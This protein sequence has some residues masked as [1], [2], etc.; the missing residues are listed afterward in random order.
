MK[1]AFLVIFACIPFYFL[2]AQIVIN[3]GSNKNYSTL[4]DEDGEYPDWI[5]LHN[6]GA[7]PVDVYNYSLTDDPLI[8][9][10]WILPHLIIPAGGYTVIF[11]SEKDRYA[12]TAF[13]TVLNTGSFI[14]TTGWNLHNFTTPFNW[15][16]ISNIVINV[17]SYSNTGYITNSVHNQSY[18]NYHSTLFSYEDGSNNA[19][20][21]QIG[22]VLAQRPN[23][24]LNGLTIGT[25]SVMN[26][27]YSYPAPYGNWYWGARHQMMIKQPELTAAGLSAGNIN[28]LSFDIVSTDSVNYTY[29]EYSILA[30]NDYQMPSTYYPLQ[31]YLNH[32]N[33]KLSSNGEQVY[34]FSPSQVL[35]SSLQVDCGSTYD[36]SI[37]SFPDG[38]AL[39]KK[40]QPPTPNATNNG[41]IPYDD[42]S[43]APIFSVNS[44]FHSVPFSVNIIDPNVPL[45]QIYYTTDGS[46]P[47]NSD[48]LFNGTP[49]PIYQTTV[50]RAKAYAPGFLPSTCTSVSYFFNVD[51]ITP[52]ISLVTDDNNLYGPN[53]M[54]DNYNEDWLKAAHVDYF[55]S[56]DAHNLLFKRRVGIIMDGGWGGSRSQPQHS[57]RIKFAD[58]VLG[59][60]LVNYQVIPDRPDRTIFSD[61][62][63][64]N[65]SNQYLQFPYKDACQVK[66]LAKGSNN[67][68]SAWRPVSVYI[69]GAYFGL[70]ELREKWNMEMFNTLENADPDSTEIL[71]L[72][73]F[74]NSTLRALVG[75]VQNFYDDYNSFLL[76]NPA[77]T[78][79]WT[80][81]DQYFDMQYYND[82]IIAESWM[83]NT[84]WPH[85]NVKI[86]RSN[87][88][89]HRWRFCLI[90]QE[91]ALE[92]NGWT[93]CYFDHINYIINQNPGHPYINIWMVG[94][95][96][97][98]FKNYFINR[99]ADLMN[100]L[101]QPNRMLMIEQEMFDQ[102]ASEMANEFQ[103]WGDPWNVPAQM[104]DFYDN[105][106]EFRDELVCRTPQVRNHI[107]NNYG[108]PQQVDVTLDVYPA[109]AGKIHISTITPEPYPWNG[110][111]FD[112]LPVK[113]EAIADSGYQFSHWEPNGLIADT[114]NSVYNDT[115]TTSTILFKAYFELI[116]G[117]GIENEL[118][119]DFQLYPS[120]TNNILHV[121]NTHFST[122]KPYSFEIVDIQGRIT[123]NGILSNHSAQTILQ[124][125][126]LEAGIYF[127]RL[128]TSS[129]QM[130][131]LKFVKF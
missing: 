97:G 28:S 2:Q 122:E 39:I 33:F 67:Y 25:D 112:G 26:S 49:I 46:E 92:P 10:K 24:R 116:P 32:T 41:S 34:L 94:M 38:S 127:I 55:D 85:N 82:Y 42:F 101:Y 73:A 95:Q 103:R 114:L 77:D 30:V 22:T 61:F 76:I 86:Y 1:K 75:D 104:M 126:R 9:G 111:Y 48:I 79:F 96:N 106:L 6:A 47:D 84:D 20:Y 128:K 115:L 18:T 16:G 23:I 45:A 119:L 63:L 43:L 113:I 27:P 130:V 110:I 13:T 65:G 60:G 99:F 37:G 72:S 57:F 124:V 51:H 8:P 117:A 91:L 40:F 31:G 53:G 15:D 105:H 59:E 44:S 108:L 129:H 90:D 78:G 54:F 12:T 71:S 17:C 3:E 21:D 7:A 131:S 29:I 4:A 102:T 68:Y 70:Y 93:D 81:S 83:G 125:A 56:T 109:N 36:L 89:N 66:I 19:C 88:T 118:E 100:T 64:R 62:Y 74:Y 80:Q 123:M 14:P 98:K 121:V 58:G 11:C 107:Q 50:L 35:L 87:A 52:I 5:E 69:N 120:P